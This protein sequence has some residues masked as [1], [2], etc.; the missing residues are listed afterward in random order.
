MDESKSASET[1][2]PNP[3]KEAKSGRQTL[4]DQLVS[5]DRSQILK[6][7]LPY[8]PVQER[9]LFAVTSKFLELGNTIRLFR[10][11]SADANWLLP[12]AYQ[13]TGSESDVSH[14]QE[15]REPEE[16][17]L[18][19]TSS[20]SGDPLEMLQ[21]IRGYVNGPLKEQLDALINMLVMVQMVQ[22]MNESEV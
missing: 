4:L 21:D 18:H 9:S 5:D 1:D 8:L 7:A 12:E 3:P 15:E 16:E 20:A 10:L 11:A 2:R 13:K 6:A 19:A 17:L 22:I 14:M